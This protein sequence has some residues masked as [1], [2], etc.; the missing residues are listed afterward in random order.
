GD[1][2]F[3]VGV[4]AARIERRARLDADRLARLE[5]IAVEPARHAERRRREVADEHTHRVADD[6]VPVP[7]VH[8]ALAAAL[9]GP[10][11]VARVE[12]GRQLALLPA[13][14]GSLRD[15]PLAVQCAERRE[16]D[17]LER[18][19]RSPRRV[20][21]LERVR[22]RGRGDEAL[23]ALVANVELEAHGFARAVNALRGRAPGGEMA[24]SR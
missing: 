1:A 20:E 6:D 15:T 13:D 24:E 4:C 7:F 10:G 12:A 23:V 3:R 5:K 11:R 22:S 9:S 16:R 21:D 14:R 19:H 2:R 17:A 18:M 8:V